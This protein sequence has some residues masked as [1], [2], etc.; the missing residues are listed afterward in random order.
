MASI[1]GHIVQLHRKTCLEWCP[2]LATSF[3][4]YHRSFA[5]NSTN[6]FDNCGKSQR[7]LF[8]GFRIRVVEMQ[9]L[10]E[11]KVKILFLFEPSYRPSEVC[12]QVNLEWCPYTGTLLHCNMCFLV[13]ALGNKPCHYSTHPLLPTPLNNLENCDEYFFFIYKY[14]IRCL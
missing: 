8:P 9:K 11:V 4:I 6:N 7:L 3:A 13:S 5:S 2:Y 10:G 14:I 1:F 12:Q